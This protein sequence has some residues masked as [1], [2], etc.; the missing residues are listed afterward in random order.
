VSCT[1]LKSGWAVTFPAHNRDYGFF[2]NINQWLGAG[3]VAGGLLAG[4]N[5]AEAALVMTTIVGTVSSGEDQGS[6]GIGVFGS[7]GATALTG[8]S[9]TLVYTFD[10]TKGTAVT[11]N[12][13]EIG[14]HSY[15]SS[16]PGSAVL[17]IDGIT[18]SFGGSGTGFS[19]VDKNISTTP[20]LLDYVIQ[21]TTG[22]TVNTN[23][24]GMYANSGFVNPGWAASADWRASFSSQYLPNLPAGGCIGHFGYY[25]QNPAA[26][27]DGC[28]APTSVTVSG[29]IGSVNTVQLS[30]PQTVWWFNGA[31]PA[32]YPVQITATAIP[33]GV[34]P[35][36]WKITAGLGEV[37]FPNQTASTITTPG[38]TVQVIAAGISRAP[39]DIQLTVSAQGVTSNPHALTVLAP[40]SLHPLSSENSDLP[41]ATYGYL[42]EIHYAVLDQFGHQSLSARVPLNEQWTSRA[43]ADTTTNWVQPVQDECT[44]S[45]NI[46]FLPA[47]WGDTAGGPALGNVPPPKP[48]PLSPSQ[49]SNNLTCSSPGQ[50][51][52]QHWT[53]EWRI[54]DATPGVGQRVQANTWQRYQNHA[55]H[56][57][58]ISPDP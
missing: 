52:V 3:A 10:D 28:L 12:G 35:Y 34:G 4:A 25:Q 46:T 8:K 45:C 43:I 9:F 48:A 24:S 18:I 17:T 57:G 5:V 39:N 44:G 19:K 31:K 36:T 2:Q 55:R 37:G 47:D 49:N 30:A 58:I 7:P 22:N 29:P 54:G 1:L 38:N 15:S 16:S 11:S 23:L 32:G 13:I 20:G 33:N 21:D 42:S 41:S 14:R 27:A 40:Y 50:L 56:C 26:E 6:N 51:A 53:G